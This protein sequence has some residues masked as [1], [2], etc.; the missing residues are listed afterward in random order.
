MTW[1]QHLHIQ[2][3]LR[4]S[5]RQGGRNPVPPTILGFHSVRL[6]NRTPCTIRILRSGPVADLSTH[7]SRDL[8][9]SGWEVKA[10]R[11]LHLQSA[12]H[13]ANLLSV[14][15][16]GTRDGTNGTT[17][18]LRR[19]DL[20]TLEVVPTTS[21]RPLR[22]QLEYVVGLNKNGEVLFA[23]YQFKGN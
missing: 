16:N 12:A 3:T 4:T 2:V 13:A 19:A 18:V 21:A 1:R 23:R 17:T 15:L 5:P 20:C 6:D 8:V 11:S 7:S 14:D 10:D 22:L 9:G